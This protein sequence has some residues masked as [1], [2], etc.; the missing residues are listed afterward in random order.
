MLAGEQPPN[1]DLT[2]TQGATD[3]IFP[4]VGSSCFSADNPV[5]PRAHIRTQDEQAL[6]IAAAAAVTSQLLQ[7]VLWRVRRWVSTPN[8]LI[9]AKYSCTALLRH[10][11]LASLLD[12]SPNQAASPIRP[13]PPCHDPQSACC[14]SPI[15]TPRQAVAFT[16]AHPAPSPSTGLPG[17]L[18][19][20]H[21]S[22]VSKA[23]HRLG[24]FR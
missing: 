19:D 21:P 20:K 7:A 15:L 9:M 18:E 12:S 14:I 10:T 5:P 6:Q 17:S 1:S 16:F 2:T 3:L 23:V 22:L 8:G 13:S 24:S 11:L 4:S